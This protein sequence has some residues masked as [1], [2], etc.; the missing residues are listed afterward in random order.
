MTTT[1]SAP[2]E[3][4]AGYHKTLGHLSEEREIISNLS[5][6]VF[7]FLNPENV[8]ILNELRSPKGHAFLTLFL[9]VDL[10]AEVEALLNF[11]VDPNLRDLSD[12]MT[13]L[14]YACSLKLEHYL[15]MFLNHKDIN[16]HVKVAL[17]MKWIVIVK[18]IVAINY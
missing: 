6:Q 4:T 10:K 14:H 2:K 13:A 18:W 7:K 3:D 8:N 9:R 12:N 5:Q 15:P 1:T 11:G 17:N 16:V